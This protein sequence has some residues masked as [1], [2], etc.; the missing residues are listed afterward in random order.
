MPAG[1]VERCEHEAAQ[2]FAPLAHTVQHPQ[3]VLVER[4]FGSFVAGFVSA[5]PENDQVHA[6]LLELGP[7]VGLVV[8]EQAIGACP[9]QAER[10][11]HHAGAV[12]LDHHA[13]EVDWAA[14]RVTKLEKMRPVGRVDGVHRV[15]ESLGFG[16]H[17]LARAPVELH[18][19][20]ST[21]RLFLIVDVE[22]GGLGADIASLGRADASPCA[23]LRS[24]LHAPVP[25]T[26]VAI[27]PAH[28]FANIPVFGIG[29]L[30]NAVVLVRNVPFGGE[31]ESMARVSKTGLKVL[32]HG[33]CDQIGRNAGVAIVPHASD[34]ALLCRCRLF[35]R[36]VERPHPA[37]GGVLDVD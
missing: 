3:V 20:L 28:D 11:V 1:L 8:V 24:R 5:E 30:P 12:A 15:A 19:E 21:A 32:S 7:D 4:L 33:R 25:V 10:V 6:P 2:A 31:N 26:A 9:H 17:D 23:W 29:R 13:V 16:R 14:S 36:F 27:L 37:T 35:E 22:P 34:R 18:R